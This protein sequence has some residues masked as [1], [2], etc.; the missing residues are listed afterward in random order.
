MYIFID[1]DDS[2]RIIVHK[3]EEVSELK[4]INS[5]KPT[6]KDDSS[7][8]SAKLPPRPQGL[9]HLPYKLP[10]KPNNLVNQV[11]VSQNNGSNKSIDISQREQSKEN[12]R[13][14]GA[15][16][17]NDMKPVPMTP[18]PRSRV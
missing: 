11:N 1:L 18:V 2:P 8:P 9:F 15:R 13:N 14:I 7:N 10:P 6:K 16:I 17:L 12:L 3:K 5:C 4:P